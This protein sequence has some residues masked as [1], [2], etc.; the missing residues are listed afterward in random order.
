[1]IRV[2]R[3]KPGA[4][5]SLLFV[6]LLTIALTAAP[7]T[8]ALA[9]NGSFST[10]GSMNFARDGHTATLLQ[11]GEVLVAGGFNYTQGDLTSAELYTLRKASGR[12][13]AA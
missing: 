12:S 1:M 7:V 4:I 8:P 9:G 10:T 3:Y 2:E 5:R 11:N 6:G 13:R